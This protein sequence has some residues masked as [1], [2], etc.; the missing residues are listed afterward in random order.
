M[1]SK[2]RR[3]KKEKQVNIILPIIGV[4]IL[5]IVVLIT[6]YHSL[7]KTIMP[8]LKTQIT[9]DYMTFNYIENKNNIITITNNYKTSDNIGKKSKINKFDFTIANDI[10]TNKNNYEVQLIKIAADIDT[11]YLKFYLTDKSNNPVSNFNE[12]KNYDT[13]ENTT[14]GKI[15]YRGS[16][17]KKREKLR[18]RVWI[19]KDYKEKDTTKS[20]SFKIKVVPLD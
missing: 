9:K 11:K 8:S 15:L 13:L 2:K 1:K 3:K 19:S 16:L 14:E 7:L 20:A 17:N 18:L 5:I 10:N 6:S 12:I 4:F